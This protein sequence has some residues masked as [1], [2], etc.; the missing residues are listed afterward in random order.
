MKLIRFSL[1]GS[2]PRFGVVIGGRAVAFASLQQRSGVTGFD[3]LGSLR[4]HVGEPVR[5]LLPSRWSLRPA[6]QKFHG[7]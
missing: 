7:Q 4:R 2:K 5:K 3:R 1:G 6:L